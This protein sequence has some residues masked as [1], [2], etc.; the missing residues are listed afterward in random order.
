[1]AAGLPNEGG[2]TP[3]ERDGKLRDF[4]WGKQWPPPNGAGNYADSSLRRTG[5][6]T[7]TGFHDGFAQTAPVGSF[8]A[9]RAGLHDMGGNVWQWCLDGYK[10]SGRFKDWGVLRG[11]SWANAAQAELRAAY[12]NVVDRNERD[13]IYG[14]RCVL[15]TEPAR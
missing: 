6:A 14:F 5:A 11:G 4:P 13:V 15:E 8:A 9:N 7:I 2:S 12:R 1:M 10:G 3:E